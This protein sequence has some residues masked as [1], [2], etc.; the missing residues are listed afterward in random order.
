MR[1]DIP[2]RVTVRPP[3]IHIITRGVETGRP[4]GTWERI[5]KESGTRNRKV[6]LKELGVK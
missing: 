1:P 2:N 3:I 5:V 6:R 4:S